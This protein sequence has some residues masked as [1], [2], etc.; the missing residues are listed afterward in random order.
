MENAVIYARYSSDKQTE[1]SIEAQVRACREYAER[2][3]LYVKNVY[4]D[5]AVSGKGNKTAS[6]KQYQR[7]L[8]D[9]DKGAVKTILIHK[10]DR[11]ARNLGEHVNLEA[12]LKADGTRLV[13]VAQDFGTSSEAKIMRA[14][15]WSLSEYYIDNLASETRKGLRE[16]ALKGLHTGGYPPFG[17][18]V[19]GEKGNRHYQINDMEAGY[20]RKIFD[21]AQSGEGFAALIEEMEAAGIKGKRGKPIRYPQIYEILRNEKYT[22]VY[23]YS[24]TEAVR[25]G[26][27]RAK[28]EAIRIEGG[29]PAII[30]KEQFAE[31]Q[32]IM[33]ERQH[34][35]RKASYLCSGLVYCQCGARMHGITSR[36]KGHEYQYF[37]CSKKCGAAVVH[38]EE[39]DAAAVKYVRELLTPG[40]QQRIA[41][42][43]RQYQAG[44]GAR[45]TEFKQAVKKRV[46]EKQDQYDAL[47]NNLSGGTL[48]PE[49]VADVGNR[50][51][52]LKAEI[53]A[54]EAAEPPKD[55]TT[56]T[57]KAWLENI[58]A[59]PDREA[60][61]LLIERINVLRTGDETEKTVFNMQST[62]K[63]VLG[64]NG[65]GDRI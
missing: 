45:M 64:N 62:L 53:A 47:M 14:L 37:T 39:V 8:R 4:A 7:L 17:W 58:K 30:G 24:P 22:G 36:R 50:M 40:N 35:G 2:H 59:A 21:A 13:A 31:V 10:Y 11:I 12:R 15:M 54:L 3:G 46:R 25:R 9:C 61:R 60:V 16:T 65:C 57:V 63:T 5:E 19:V 38:M 1:E 32:K 18:D 27:R 43:L 44:E 49:V 56:E 51:R 41:D 6:R 23:L 55:F 42:A 26:D 20:V 34:T 29:I 28:S 33:R 48:P 52:E